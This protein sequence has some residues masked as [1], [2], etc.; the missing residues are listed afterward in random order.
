MIWSEVQICY[1]VC[2]IRL[3]LTETLTYC[4]FRGVKWAVPD[5]ARS[6]TRPSWHGGLCKSVMSCVF[7]SFYPSNAIF[8]FL[9]FY[10]SYKSCKGFKGNLVEKFNRKDLNSP[11]LSG[12]GWVWPNHMCSYSFLYVYL[13]FFGL[14]SQKW[15]YN[16]HIRS[17]A[18]M[19]WPDT[20]HARSHLCSIT[21]N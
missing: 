21:K 12:V 7:W 18:W 19:T 11:L 17:T 20:I 8:T 15:K 14:T 16:K 13:Y 3:M 6:T 5:M 2:K 4:Q 9:Y 1:W 10:I